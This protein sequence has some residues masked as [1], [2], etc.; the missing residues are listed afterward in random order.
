MRGTMIRWLTG[1]GIPAVIL[2]AAVSRIARPDATEARLRQPVAVVPADEGRRLFIAN[3]RAGSVSVV[4]VDRRQVLAE[5]VVGRMLADLTDAGE[6]RLLAVDEAA[7]ELIVL[8]RRGD[9]LDVT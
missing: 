3:R 8:V 2:L 9:S 5:P 1:C 6:G 7:N 4:D